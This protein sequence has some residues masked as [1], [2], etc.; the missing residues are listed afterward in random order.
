MTVSPSKSAAIH[1]TCF[2][3]L[4]SF[5]YVAKSSFDNW[6]FQLLDLKKRIL[7]QVVRK[8]GKPFKPS[9][10][11]VRCAGFKGVLTLDP[12]L[13]GKQAIFRKSMCKF[14][15]FHRRLEV[16]Q[17]SRPQVVFLNHQVIMLLSNQGVPD[18]VFIKLQNDML[19]KLSGKRMTSRDSSQKTSDLERMITSSY[20]VLTYYMEKSEKLRFES[21]NV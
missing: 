20:L 13:L 11:Q 3:N 4:K 17:T 5:W 14:D 7:F 18:E 8:I 6:C 21:E 10:F 9:A 19:D 12:R 1:F 16:L 15:S 2:R